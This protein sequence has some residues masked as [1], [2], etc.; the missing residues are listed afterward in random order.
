MTCPKCPI[1]MRWKV[2]WEKG[3][4]SGKKG[5]RGTGSARQLEV[6]QKQSMKAEGRWKG[7]GARVTSRQLVGFVLQQQGE[8]EPDQLT[9]GQDEGAAMFETHRF[10]ILALIEGLIVRRVKANAM[11]ALDEIVTQI[12]VAGLG[13]AAGFTMELA[14]VDA[15]PPQPGE[16]GEGGHS[17]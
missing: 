13:Q 9:G 10:A 12:T 4:V 6:D 11:G 7:S 8:D 5:A 3:R 2:K 16:L 1:E 14:G 15:W 17:P